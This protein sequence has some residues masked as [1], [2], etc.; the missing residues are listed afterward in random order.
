MG[1]QDLLPCR[2]QILEMRSAKWC[3]L[4]VNIRDETWSH[5][6]FNFLVFGPMYSSF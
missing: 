4:V 2:V 6:C 1:N 3:T 5:T